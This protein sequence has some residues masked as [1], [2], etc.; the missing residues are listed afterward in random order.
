MKKKMYV[1]PQCTVIPVQREAY[2][3]SGTS[4]TNVSA[5][6]WKEVEAEDLSGTESE[7][8]PA[9]VNLWDTEFVR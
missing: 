5:A 3:L 6:N 1:K 8:Y 7:I 4:G 2:L 9:K